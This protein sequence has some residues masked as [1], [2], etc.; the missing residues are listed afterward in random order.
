MVLL[1]FAVETRI[2]TMKSCYQVCDVSMLLISQSFRSRFLFLFVSRPVLIRAMNRLEHWQEWE[3]ATKGLPR[4]SSLE[5]RTVKLPIQ[6]AQANTSEGSENAPDSRDVRRGMGKLSTSIFLS[7]RTGQRAEVNLRAFYSNHP[8]FTSGVGSLKSWKEECRGQDNVPC[9][10]SGLWQPFGTQPLFMTRR[11]DT[12]K[13][14]IWHIA[15]CVACRWPAKWHWR[16]RGPL[17][18]PWCFISTFDHLKCWSSSLS[19][20]FIYEN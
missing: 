4:H 5:I 19:Q 9:S 6:V 15:C 18:F 1:S 14:M 16:G 10:F 13:D 3:S 12:L 11:I 8:T 7:T 17:K 2:S 20:N